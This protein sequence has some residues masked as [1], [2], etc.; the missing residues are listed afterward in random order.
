MIANQSTSAGSVQAGN[1]LTDL[2]PV[3]HDVARKPVLGIGYGVRVRGLAVKDGRILDDQW[4]GTL[5]DTGIVGFVGWIWLVGRVW[6]RVGRSARDDHTVDGWLRVGLLASIASFSVGMLTFDAFSF[7]QVTF[8]F[9]IVLAI[10]S[11]VV[12]RP[13]LMPD[14]HL[15]S[16]TTHNL[17]EASR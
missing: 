13:R 12:L 16:C 1:R 5:Y 14:H 11:I 17:G 2:G 7:T 10:A 3:L 8:V 9:Y 6:R 15:G 4:L